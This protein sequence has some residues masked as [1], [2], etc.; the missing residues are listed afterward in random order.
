M[1][2][3]LKYMGH[4]NPVLRGVCIVAMYSFF[5]KCS[6]VYLIS[7]S[8]VVP[9]YAQTTI[10]PDIEKTYKGEVLDILSSEKRE[11]PNT[12]VQEEY[13]TL[14]VKI[15]FGDKVG[16]T[17]TIQ[18]AVISTN[19]GDSLYIKYLKTSDGTELYTVSEPYRLNVLL[20]LCILFVVVVI[21]FGGKHGVLSL[22]SLVVSFSSMFFILFPELLK[23]ANPLLVSIMIA[24]ICLFVVMFFS[25]GFNYVTLSAYLGCMLSIVITLF[26]AHYAVIA[27]R[28]SGFADDES[29]YLN[30][31]T[32]GHLNFQALLIAAIIIGVI[33][34]VD[35]V[36]ITQASVVAELN[37]TN[38]TISTKELYAR[39]MKV[40][41]DHSAALIN[42][43]ILAYAGASLPLLLLL[44]TSDTPL[45][46]L[47]NREVIAT[48]I[49]RTIVG[50][51]GLV[52]LVPCSTL[53]AVLL[54]KRNKK[55]NI[56]SIHIPHHH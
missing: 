54:I 14:R 39:A 49:I 38:T 1:L 23:G 15:T 31:A 22:I 30:I 20:Y 26:L 37:S 42:T 16:R 44:Y 24:M 52:I 10:L 48:E 45:L 19:V 36:A 50:S 25:H 35:D 8:F 53:I 17:I 27:A 5:K 55:R 6:L 2:I 43:L 33:G 11:V 21:I 40:G 7:F 29:V 41:K 3:P 47:I 12:D 46:E 18:D 28:L 13:K 9:L 32:G 56:N 34:V 4:V 51:I